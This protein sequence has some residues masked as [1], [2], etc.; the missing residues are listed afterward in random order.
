VQHSQ[1]PGPAAR[2][3]LVT[4]TEFPVE[5]PPVNAAVPFGLPR[6]VGPS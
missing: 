6:P 2:A 5:V 3:G 1:W 4:V